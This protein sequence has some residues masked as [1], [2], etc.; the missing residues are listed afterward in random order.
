MPHRFI[1]AAFPL[2]GPEVY[3]M[4][5]TFYT[6]T[7]V[8]AFGSTATGVQT[9]QATAGDLYSQ[10][11][12]VILLIAATFAMFGMIRS[13]HTGH[14]QVEFYGTLMVLACMVGYA[15]AIVWRFWNDGDVQRLP[16]S[17][18][19]MLIGILPFWR[20]RAILLRPHGGPPATPRLDEQNHPVSEAAVLDPDESIRLAPRAP[21]ADGAPDLVSSRSTRIHRPIT[22]EIAIIPARAG[23]HDGA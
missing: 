18:L 8:Y 1:I 12:P 10:I 13:R 3:K 22:G 7:I 15:S 16:A 5:L 23:A 2:S 20:L 4:L 11:W 17:L 21:E 14:V 19:P 9:I 6:V